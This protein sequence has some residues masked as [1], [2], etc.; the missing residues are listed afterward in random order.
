MKFCSVCGN[1]PD[2]AYRIYG[3]YAG[4]QGKN[5]ETQIG[6]FNRKPGF[7]YLVWGF[8]TASTGTCGSDAA[9]DLSFCD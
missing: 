7:L 1:F 8:V 5:Y 3:V 9:C 2:I 6:I 4:I